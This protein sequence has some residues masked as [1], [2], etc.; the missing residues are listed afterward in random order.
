MRLRNAAYTPRI[1]ILVFLLLGMAQQAAAGDTALTFKN[2]TSQ[3]L[4]VSV[5]H[6]GCGMTP[7]RD[8]RPKCWSKTV[9]SGGTET[10]E[11]SGWVTNFSDIMAYTTMGVELAAGVALIVA[12]GGTAAVAEGPAFAAEIEGTSVV[13]S[14]AETSALEEGLMTPK[15]LP[16][17]QQSKARRVMKL[18]GANALAW[19]GGEAYTKLTEDWTVLI[20][21]ASDQGMLGTQ[22][23]LKRPRSV[24]K[25]DGNLAY[26]IEDLTDTS[27]WS[28]YE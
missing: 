5:Y 18:L 23:N 11:P 24:C 1:M 2:Q 7:W 15:E 16:A 20:G 4:W 19:I 25:H 21:V 6:A 22:E 27:N 28:N 17:A 14:D 26:V 8:Y 12:S 10:Y 9:T 3:T 13:L